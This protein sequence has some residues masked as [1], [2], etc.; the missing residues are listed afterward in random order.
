M[1]RRL[2]R[3]PAYPTPPTAAAL[4]QAAEALSP[5]MSAVLERLVAAYLTGTPVQFTAA[6]NAMLM[7]SGLALSLINRTPGAAV[8]IGRMG[9]GVVAQNPESHKFVGIAG[10]VLLGGAR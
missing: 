4:Q 5:G 9:A 1:S 10:P 8:R 2:R 7:A 3:N 6:D